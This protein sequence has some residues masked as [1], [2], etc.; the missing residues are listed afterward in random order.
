MKR[1]PSGS[2]AINLCRRLQGIVSP[3]STTRCFFKTFLALSWNLELLVTYDGGMCESIGE[4]DG[5]REPLEIVDAALQR[6]ETASNEKSRAS[7]VGSMLRFI[8]PRLKGYQEK[9]LLLVMSGMRFESKYFQQT[10]ELNQF[11]QEIKLFL[12]GVLNCA[13]LQPVQESDRQV[14]LMDRLTSRL[15][16]PDLENTNVRLKDTIDLSCSALQQ[17]RHFE[18][19]PRFYGSIAYVFSSTSLCK[20]S[21]IDILTLVDTIYKKY[22]EYDIDKQ[23][24]NVSGSSFE[25]VAEGLDTLKTI[26]HDKNKGLDKEVPLMDEID[27]KLEF[28]VMNNGSFFAGKLLENG[29]TLADYSIQKEYNL[30]LV[31]CLRGSA[32]SKFLDFKNVLMARNGGMRESIGEML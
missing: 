29:R 5:H 9:N 8:E 7:A 1:H 3:S 22:D 15:S 25:V 28:E 32:F 27:T 31:L 10:D 18:I 20:T 12:D 17:P 16:M 26:A 24:F 2:A 30:H 19:P 14:P 21:V 4:Y 13:V 6:A 11:R 23:D